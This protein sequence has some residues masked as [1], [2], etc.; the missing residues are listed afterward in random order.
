[1]EQDR[2]AISFSLEAFIEDFLIPIAADGKLEAWEETPLLLAYHI[3]GVVETLIAADREGPEEV[4]R[5]AETTRNAVRDARAAGPRAWTAQA[6][7]QALDRARAHSRARLGISDA[8]KLDDWFRRQA[9]SS[10]VSIE[11]PDQPS[12]SV[13]LSARPFDRKLLGRFQRWIEEVVEEVKEPEDD[14][15]PPAAEPERSPEPGAPAEPSPAP[16]AGPAP[17]G[18]VTH[19]AEEAAWR[20]VVERS[21]QAALHRRAPEILDRARALLDGEGL[22]SMA[23]GSSRAET[24]RGAV[25]VTPEELEQHGNLWFIGD[26]HADLLA[27]ECALALIKGFDAPSPPTM[28]FLGDLIDDGAH[29]YEV[30][31]RVL[32]LVHAEAGRVCLVAGN[33]DEALRCDDGIFTSDV[34]PSDFDD[35]LN[36][37]SK[38]EDAAKRG[39]GPVVV[40]LFQRTPRAL[41]L[42]D[43]L[44]AV[45]GG[46]PQSDIWPRIT[47]PEALNDPLC[48]Q[49]FVWTRAH[50]RARKRCPNRGSRSAEFGRLD[51]EG[52]CELTG[53]LPTPVARMIR[54]HDHF[55][56]RYRLYER[57]EKNPVLTINTMSRRL[58][59]EWRG[60]LERCPCIGRW[61]PGQVPEVHRIEIPPEAIQ[62]VYGEEEG[63]EHAG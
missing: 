48:L 21:T 32:D 8:K 7:S 35:W 12:G 46:I 4:A 33:H 55:D 9:E 45:H 15:A 49:D 61:I 53:F 41:F 6:L 20:G 51:F 50:E 47:S 31:L 2:P 11:I 26:L 19:V 59:R 14:E 5:L 28:V 29:D 17:G 37:H 30:M 62:A 13:L 18:V 27:L 25:I 10:G 60:P 3:Y 54:G 40:E 63:P 16:T 58:A 39:I 44:L 52:F 42:P 57:Y 36:E 24:A 1:M 34:S 22:P 38:D 56:E 43:G 23:F